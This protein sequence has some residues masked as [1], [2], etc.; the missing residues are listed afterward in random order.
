MWLR[1]EIIYSR[2]CGYTVCRSPRAR[3]QDGRG[4]SCIEAGPR[5]APGVLNPAALSWGWGGGSWWPGV[6]LPPGPLDLAPPGRAQFIFTPARHLGSARPRHL[7]RVLGICPQL[8]GGPGFVCWTSDSCWIPTFLQPRSSGC[9]GSGPGLVGSAL[10]AGNH[11][12]QPGGIW[13]GALPARHPHP[14]PGQSP[15]A[16]AASLHFKAGGGGGGALGASRPPACPVPPGA[17][18]P[19]PALWK[20][21]GC[22]SR[23]PF[24]AQSSAT[25]PGWLPS[26]LLASSLL[27]CLP[28]MAHHFWH[29][30]LLP[31]P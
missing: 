11:R 15:A 22:F 5:W 25:M 6:A 1:P 16:A 10:P 14:M 17:G 28:V 2:T 21:L 20:A 27:A 3:T 7:C 12:A 4:F 19:M 24:A 30:P 29:L 31:L 8:E 18:A 26:S 9:E 13:F 23:C